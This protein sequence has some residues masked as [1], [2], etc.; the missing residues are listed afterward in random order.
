ME[1]YICAKERNLLCPT[2]DHGRGILRVFIFLLKIWNKD[3]ET[4]FLV[5]YF[6]HQ[7]AQFTLLMC[8]PLQMS[9]Y[10][11]GPVVI[12]KTMIPYSRIGAMSRCSRE[13]LSLSLPS[14][15]YYTSPPSLSVR[16]FP[17]WFGQI[18]CL[19]GLKIKDDS[20]DYT[21]LYVRAIVYINFDQKPA[22]LK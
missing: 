9:V 13:S 10:S 19:N 3:N 2:I 11:T 16:N 17:G 5:E 15:D 20:A 1:N 14:S 21:R 12:K 18:Y 7:F 22:C 8:Q 4:S 6:L